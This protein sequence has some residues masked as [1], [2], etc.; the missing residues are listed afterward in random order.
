M[1]G[2]SAGS[3]AIDGYHAHVYFDP[4]TR[5]RAAALREE[6]AAALGVEVRALSDEPRGPHPV[7]QFR[8]TFANAQFADVVP[9]LMLN[10][11]GLDVLVHPLTDNSYDDHSRYA[12]WLGS[13]VALRLNPASRGYRAEQ[14]PS[15]ALSGWGHARRLC[16]RPPARHLP[17]VSDG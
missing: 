9:W 17:S 11:Q 7:P 4:A 2:I 8:F 1:S 13:P 10:R 6:I 15:G 3:P 12:V 5:A 14:I 16:D